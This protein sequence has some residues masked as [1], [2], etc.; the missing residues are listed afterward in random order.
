MPTLQIGNLNYAVRGHDLVRLF[1]KYGTVHDATVLTYAS[2]N[3]G[4]E[5]SRGFG[6]V[7]LDADKAKQAVAEMNQS[8]FQGRPLKV[9]DVDLALRSGPAQNV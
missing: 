7:T 9:C 6:F 2:K 8:E 3:G 4:H 1:E 5:L